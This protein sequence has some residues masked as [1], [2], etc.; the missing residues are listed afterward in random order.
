MMGYY[1][2]GFGP[3]GFNPFS[4]IGQFL[5]Q[6]FRSCLALAVVVAIIAI[7]SFIAGFVFC[8]GGFPS[9]QQT[10]QTTDGRTTEG[11][12]SPQGIGNGQPTGASSSMSPPTPTPGYDVQMPRTRPRRDLP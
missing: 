12:Q 10:A 4:M 1:P 11:A 7:S 9:N 5:V 8:K 2:N 6:F 3:G